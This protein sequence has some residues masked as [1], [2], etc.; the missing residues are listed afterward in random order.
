MDWL[1]FCKAVG[2]KAFAASK[3]MH[4][5]PG[6]AQIVGIGKGGDQTLKI[7]QTVENAVIAEFKKL[8]IPALLITEETG[9]VRIGTAEPEAFLVVD[10]LDGST[11]ARS[12][13]DMFALSIAV[14]EK[15]D[16]RTARFAFIKNLVS[17]TEYWAE[18]GKGAFKNGRP[19]RTNDHEKISYLILAATPDKPRD[20][21]IRMMNVSSHCRY[22]RIPGTI[23]LDFCLVAEGNWDALVTAGRIRV[24]DFAA[25]H[26]IVREAG[27]IVE[28]EPSPEVSVTGRSKIEAY[29][30][31]NIQEQVKAYERG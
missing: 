13:I 30:N 16:L 8:K 6:A 1:K 31:K 9:E 26:L 4:G 18:K 23:A 12:G 19:I 29:A 15:R 7:D 17:G 28:M 3:R 21:M 10:P 11:N 24:L 27:G 5:Q 22:T 2:K 14:L 25:G 20:E